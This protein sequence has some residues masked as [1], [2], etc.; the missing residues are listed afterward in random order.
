MEEYIFGPVE[1]DCSAAVAA[2]IAYCKE[3]AIKRLRFLEGEYHFYPEMAAEDENC[4]VSNHGYNGYKRCAFLIKDME[5]FTVEGSGSLLVF[6]GAM[7]AFIVRR[8]RHITI[9]GFRILYEKTMH[10]SFLV[11]GATA[12]YVDITPC[13]AQGYVYENGLLYLEN[14]QGYRNL[15]Y[16]CEERNYFNREFATGEQCFGMDFLYLQ[17]EDIGGTIRVFRPPRKPQVG[18][19]V[20]LI[21]AHRYCNGILLLDSEQVRVSDCCIYSC[22]GVAYHAQLCRDVTLE[23]C[24]TDLYPGRF[25][26]ANADASHFVGCRGRVVVRGCR[27]ENQLDD[28]MNVHGVYTRIIWK[29]EQSIV[30]K[31][32]HEQCRGIG[33]FCDGCR[34]SVLADKSLLP[35]RTA[36]VTKARPV[37]IESTRL[38]LEGGTDGIQAGDIVDSID[39][40]PEETIIEQNVFL[41]NRARGI[42]LGSRGKTVVRRNY[43]HV[44]GTAIKLESDCTYWYESGGVQDLLIEDNV[45]DNCR[46]IDSGTWGD[47]V[48][49]TTPREALEQ[50]RYYHNTIVI[51]NNDF[52]SC[53]VKAINVEN[54][55]HLVIRGN[56][57]NAVSDTVAYRHCGKTDVSR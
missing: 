13:S 22:Y 47:E 46:Y 38:W 12:E 41:N 49:Y 48:I 23:R 7:N 27:F 9:S 53:P 20:I 3:N 39:F 29:D 35:R 56:T 51:Q 25:F 57:W 5:D 30:V 16:S 42:L 32:V 26:S 2:A 31:Y 15:V 44:P 21:A 34:V 43:F 28:A 6:H 40:Y 11:K 52:S 37:N 8:S 18:N 50:G 33:L 19:I 36:Y 14:E 10:G 24:R 55:A 45:F 54:I 17:T 4:C 1:G